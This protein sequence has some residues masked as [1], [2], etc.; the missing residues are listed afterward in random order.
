MN[1][2]DAIVSDYA[3]LLGAQATVLGFRWRRS[4]VDRQQPAEERGDERQEDR[5]EDG[6]LHY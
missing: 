6:P 5:E 3:E 2:I 1:P 4:Q